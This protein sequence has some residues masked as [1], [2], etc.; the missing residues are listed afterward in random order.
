ME[1]KKKLKNIAIVLISLCLFIAFLLSP[2]FNMK[3]INVVG[4]KHYQEEE[5]VEALSDINNKNFLISLFKHTPF[6]HLDYIFKG[7]IYNI[8]QKLLFDKPYIK[9]VTVSFSFPGTGEVVIQ[10]RIP[11]FY[12]QAGDEY[13][14]VDTEGFVLEATSSVDKEN[15][16]VVQGIEVSDYRVGNS[17]AG[18]GTDPQLEMAIKLCNGMK[19]I[20][21]S[22]G[23]VDII[24]VSSVNRIWMFVKP[25]LSICLGNEDDMNVKLSA[26]KEILLSGYGGDS[27]GI[28]DFTNGKNPIF[29]ENPEIEDILPGEGILPEG[30]GSEG[31]N[32]GEP[33]PEDAVPTAT[34]APTE[35][36]TPENNENVPEVDNNGGVDVEDGF[37]DI[38]TENSE[39]G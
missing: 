28:I 9:T 1:K 5:I 12:I 13:L 29:K 20:K 6:S 24:D 19:Q 10:E 2:L 36:P 7:R 39:Q 21:L 34:P 14:L 26:L 4:A 31:E 25:S 11:I 33:N 18:K 35:A 30:E 15:F 16:P 17:L 38:D 8:E 23:L 37:L 3:T 32:A 27:N 22:D